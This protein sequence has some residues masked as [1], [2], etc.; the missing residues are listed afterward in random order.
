MRILLFTT[1]ILANIFSVAAAND[2][3][4]IED[5]ARLPA[6]RQ[7]DIAPGGKHLL[8]RFESDGRYYASV[9]ALGK[10][11]MD[12]KYAAREDDDVSVE[13]LRWVSADRLVLSIGSAG[14]RYGTDT[15]ETRLFGLDA[16]DDKLEPL[17]RTRRD[18]V[19]QQF[20]DDIVS[21]IDN[22]PDHILLQYRKDPYTAYPTVYRVPV[23]KRGIHKIV[24]RWKSKVYDWRADHTGVVRSGRG[25]SNDAE[26]KPYLIIRAHEKG[27]WRD[28][29]HRI[30]PGAPD[31]FIRGFSGDPELI[32]VESG[33]EFDPP[34]L[35]EYNI[36]TDK[37]EN[38]IFR[39][40]ASEIGGIKIDKNTG[41]IRGIGYGEEADRIRW[42]DPSIGK[43]T[44]QIRDLF[45]G[46]AVTLI[47]E[48]IDSN[49]AIY[50]IS[51]LLEPGT[52]YAFD[53]K[54]RNLMSIGNQ[55]PELADYTLA[56]VVKEQFTARDG[57]EIPSYVT[58][59]VGAKTLDD[60][61]NA[62]FVILPHGGPTARDFLRFDYWS[63][64]LASRGYAVFQLN[65]RGSAGYGQAFRDA[66]D[67]EWGQAMQDDI[68][69]GAKW[70]VEQGY[71]DKDR[72]AI[73]GGSYGGYAALMGGAKTP[74]LYQCIVSFAGV[75]DLRDLLRR[76][77][78]Y[79]G[80]K[81]GTRHIGR[82]WKDR[83]MLNENSPVRLAANFQAPVLLMHGKDDRVVDVKQSRDMKR[84]LE[85]ADKAVTYIEF[86]SGDHYLSLYANRLRFLQETEEFLGD[87][88]NS[89]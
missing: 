58:L 25:Y 15:R 17:F 74:D 56:P 37:F 18:E 7:I 42:L 19:P 51:G 57:L 84:A 45:P 40:Q 61:N 49:Y 3:P 35:Y 83:D 88:L 30:A 33:H 71:A 11:T 23:N 24:Q 4:P 66:G 65:F 36:T 77:R 68:T 2:A 10:N 59:P 41:K 80:G 20:E 47:R 87:C 32:Y 64:F 34:G 38:L 8:G 26:T 81:A 44:K 28:I 27:E 31:F 29:S 69:D 12:L 85:R 13:T 63:Q 39:D 5:F 70:L 86:E 55:Y 46:K 50:E 67:K 6:L 16:D 53:R 54:G 76:D 78:K 72:I 82:L 21:W 1:A 79:I 14:R 48:S 62:P 89:D 22:D 73:M 60:V 9:F 43:E 52:Y 75:A